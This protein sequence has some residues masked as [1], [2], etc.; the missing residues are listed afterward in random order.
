[1][2]TRT[3]CPGSTQSGPSRLTQ[4]GLSSA[5]L[6]M[7]A[8]V[9]RGLAIAA[10][11]L[12]LWIIAAL[13]TGKTFVLGWGQTPRIASRRKDPG[14]FWFM[15]IVLGLMAGAFTIQ[16]A[17][18]DPAA[19]LAPAIGSAIVVAGVALV[20][21]PIWRA[22]GHFFR[23]PTPVEPPTISR[24]RKSNAAVVARGWS[25]ED[26]KQIIADFSGLYD[27]PDGWV[28]IERRADDVSTLAFAD[29]VT[30]ETL[31]FL[32]NY[33]TY[34]NGFDLSQRS[35]GVV[36][37][38]QLT[39]DFGAPNDDLVGKEALVYVPSN[40]TEHDQ[41]YVHSDAQTYIVPLADFV[42]RVTGDAR[43]PAAIS[44]L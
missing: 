22:I 13:R 39:H 31:C 10:A 24:K 36:A 4:R 3:E 26:L 30:P 35:T 16:V 8:A 17:I 7:G 11:G 6:C 33:L 27:L 41:V 15:L 42:W 5:R 19:L 20:P 29:A 32:V 43:L 18:H 9:L 38:V 25:R 34:P 23:G 21:K 28:E 14:D 12:V 2:R 40:D 37:R 1:M 44:G